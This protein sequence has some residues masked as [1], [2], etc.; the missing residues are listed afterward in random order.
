[1]N[2]MKVSVKVS[3][4]ALHVIMDGVSKLVARP[5]DDKDLVPYAIHIACIE[6]KAGD[7]L[8]LQIKSDSVL[9]ALRLDDLREGEENWLGVAEL[10]AYKNLT[11]AIGD[12]EACYKVERVHE[13][14]GMLVNN[15]RLLATPRTINLRRRQAKRDMILVPCFT[16]GRKLGK[17][18]GSIQVEYVLQVLSESRLARLFPTVED[19]RLK[20]MTILD[21]QGRYKVVEEETKVYRLLDPKTGKLDPIAVF[22]GIA[23]PPEY[24]QDEITWLQYEKSRKAIKEGVKRQ[25]KDGSINHYIFLT[26]SSSGQRTMTMMMIEKGVSLPE[27]ILN[28]LPAEYRTE[29][30][31]LPLVEQFWDILTYGGWMVS[32][33]DRHGVPAKVNSRIGLALSSSI[34]L[35]AIKSCQM[36]R[37]R[38]AWSETVR[39]KL[40]VMYQKKGWS[41]ERIAANLVLIEKHWK[42][43]IWDGTQFIRQSAALKK[44]RRYNIHRD[45][46]QRWTEDNVIGT[47]IQF[48]YAGAKGTA[49][50]VPDEFLDEVVVDGEAIF[51]G[52]DLILEPASVKY[53]WNPTVYAG[54][55]L[56][57]HFEL[58]GISKSSYSDTVDGQFLSCLKFE[59]IEQMDL[60]RERLRMNIAKTMAKVN[61]IGLSRLA[62]GVIAEV[63]EDDPEVARYSPNR[64]FMDGWLQD[65]PRTTGPVDEPAVVNGIFGADNGSV[66]RADN[67]K[68]A[69]DGGRFFML[70]D[71]SPLWT[72]TWVKTDKNDFLTGRPMY[73][74]YAGTGV[75]EA[76]EAWASGRT[77]HLAMYR[78]PL[79]VAGE[80]VHVTGVTS[81]TDE[82][83]QR[84]YGSMQ[85]IVV[86]SIWSPAANLMGGGDFDGD[87]AMV[88]W[89]SMILPMIEDTDVVLVDVSGKAVSVELSYENVR[90]SVANSLANAGIGLITN[91]G[92]TWQE[93]RQIVRGILLQQPKTVSLPRIKVWNSKAQ[94]EELQGL[95][96]FLVDNHQ[97]GQWRRGAAYLAQ[98]TLNKRPQLDNWE[99][100]ACLAISKL[101]NIEKELNVKQLDF[102]TFSNVVAPILLRACEGAIQV[103]RYL[104]ELAI[105]TAKSDIWALYK[106]TTDG[107]LSTRHDF[108]YVALTIRPLWK[109]EKKSFSSGLTP[110]GIVNDFN[111]KAYAEARKN[112]LS[113]CK[114][115]PYLNSAPNDELFGIMDSMVKAYNESMRAILR[116]CEEINDRDR[117]REFRGREQD[118]LKTSNTR[119]VLDLQAKYGP[120]AVLRA[121]YTATHKHANLM[122]GSKMSFVYRML[123]EELLAY[124]NNSKEDCQVLPLKV[125]PNL[126]YGKTVTDGSVTSHYE[127][128]KTYILDQEGDI[129][130]RVTTT[131]SNNGPWELRTHKGNAFVFYH[132]QRIERTVTSKDFGHKIRLIG[133][134]SYGQSPESL[135]ALF[136]QKKGHMSHRIQLSRHA[137]VVSFHKETR[138]TTNGL[139]VPCIVMT[140]GDQ[141]VGTVTPDTANHILPLLDQ[142]DTFIAEIKPD[143]NAKASV[144]LTLLDQFVA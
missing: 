93:I 80:I 26:V 110:M 6:A 128:G 106:R 105:N 142:G 88:I 69:I 89:D 135:L 141:P 131:L 66:H 58:V 11:L 5:A 60:L 100:E 30:M 108:D 98:E 111:Q 33:K 37:A 76:D 57:P 64:T 79:N 123:T 43:D 84:L 73:D 1:M 75:L 124:M 99:K 87:K 68:I 71:I 24:E 119:K 96:I 107:K 22:Q 21:A 143:P 18:K 28:E 40:I 92:S 17:E 34:S 74:L 36:G 55:M 117:E 59:S 31:G 39:G 27:A 61:D 67:G 9:A 49:L 35:G 120:L 138:I 29:L 23:M 112:A 16:P 10:A 115:D 2:T 125:I 91:Y 140:V 12:Q 42:E 130:G 102:E 7:R 139:E 122:T 83:A 94:Q 62:S 127:E 129:I 46:G 136:K 70:P 132:Q 133:L 86:L 126:L 4:K 95:G 51:A 48:R 114:L 45:D 97:S 137:N 52:Y 63:S 116:R 113:M 25:N 118:A 109:R 20:R 32:M 82:K 134:S 104:Q 77:G 90:D 47:L 121:A 44:L 14:K 81:F 78:N 103:V 144:T 41:D 15:G 13:G 8:D 53:D 38:L 65:C 50:V 56:E 54:A 85:S 72:G 101:Y 19:P 3:T